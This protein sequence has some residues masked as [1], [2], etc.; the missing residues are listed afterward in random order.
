MA[1][2]I[3]IYCNR[4][5]LSSS[6]HLI[7]VSFLSLSTSL[8]IL[9]RSLA[10]ICCYKLRLLISRLELIAFIAVELFY[11]MH[12]RTFNVCTVENDD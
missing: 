2:E 10:S 3:A 8:A 5:S 6:L 9:I 7:L 1:I 11:G 12:R 4:I